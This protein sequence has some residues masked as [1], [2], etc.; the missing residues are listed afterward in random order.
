MR[1]TATTDRLFRAILSLQNIEE[2]YEFFDDV[3]TIN[4]LVAMSQ[5]FE[6]ARLLDEK[7]NY[8]NI[9]AKTGVSTATIG[10]VSRCLAYG[11]GGY[12]KALDRLKES[13]K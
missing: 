3:C 5:R 10:R 9:N 7:E 6:V 4:E 12:R 13:E 1:Q 8:Q 2:C 11:S